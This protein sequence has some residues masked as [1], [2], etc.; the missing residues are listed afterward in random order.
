MGGRQNP[1]LGTTLIW[2]MNTSQMLS[3]KSMRGPRGSRQAE[4]SGYPDHTLRRSRS[5]GTDSMLHKSSITES[6]QAA[7]H[8]AC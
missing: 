3:A 5:D 8:L 6:D 1:G 4:T 7:I 2:S